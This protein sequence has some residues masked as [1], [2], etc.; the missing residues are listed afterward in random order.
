MSERVRLIVRPLVRETIRRVQLLAAEH[1]HGN[2]L[3][4]Q[5]GDEC[6][7]ESR[8]ALDLLGVIYRRP[9]LRFVEHG[10]FDSPPVLVHHAEIGVFL[11]IPV[12]IVWEQAVVPV[13]DRDGAVHAKLPQTRP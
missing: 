9:T 1:P 8:A 11:I 12:R 7:G 3:A 10:R 2:P 13:A 6:R 5:V 4:L